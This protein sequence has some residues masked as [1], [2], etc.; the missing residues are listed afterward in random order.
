MTNNLLN[1]FDSIETRLDQ[2][3]LSPSV[4]QINSLLIISEV[5]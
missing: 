5:T 4:Q 3:Q 1:L 2:V